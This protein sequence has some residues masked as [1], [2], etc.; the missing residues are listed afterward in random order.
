MRGS[1]GLGERERR[2]GGKTAGGDSGKIIVVNFLAVSGCD[3]YCTVVPSP[4]SSYDYYECT[5]L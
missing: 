1:D 5:T 3:V 2:G 4:H